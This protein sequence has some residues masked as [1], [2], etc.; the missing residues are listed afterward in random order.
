MLKQSIAIIGGGASGLYSALHAARE[1]HSKEVS[2]T[3]FEANS[4]GGRKLLITG[5]SQC[6][7]TNSAP[8]S[9]LITHYHDKKKE[10]ETILNAYSTKE[11][12]RTFTQLGL[13]LTTRDDKK[14]FP[15]SFDARDV[16]HVLLK[17]IQSENI[18]IRYQQRIEKVIYENNSF[19]LYHNNTNIGSFDALIIATGG[20]TFPKTGSKGDG[21]HISSLLGHS[22]VKPQVALTGVKV[23]DNSL[24]SLSGL[25][26]EN[27]SV[28]IR[29]NEWK[30]GSLLITH[31]GLSGPVIINASRYLSTGNTIRISYLT[32]QNGERRGAKEVQKEITLLCEKMNKSLFKTVLYTLPIPSSLIDYLLEK[33]NIDGNKKAS[34]V[35]KKTLK[36]IAIS[37]TQDVFSLNKDHMENKGMITTG[38]V[39]LSE[40]ELSTMQSTIVPHLFFCGEVIDIDGETGGYN[41]QLAWSTGAIAGREAVKSLFPN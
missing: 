23:K 41:L 13:N 9:E 1:A 33:N 20:F 39:S 30:K 7:I 10:I 11:T 25:T 32:D 12:L 4:Q 34:E 16:L 36:A 37:L 31:E 38:G 15:S 3:I 21:Y 40:I 29:P 5:S 26:I 17:G 27:T 28:E 8:V 18:Q 19:S 24:H 14:V 2:I 6:N 22:I 35:G